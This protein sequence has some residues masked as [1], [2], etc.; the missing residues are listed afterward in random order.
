MNTSHIGRK[1][2][3]SCSERSCQAGL[4]RVRE[5]SGLCL[6]E[7]THPPG[8]R[9]PLHWHE[10]AHFCLLLQGLYE[11]KCGKDV[12]VRK[13]GTLALMA[14]GAIHSNRIYN[15]GIR[16]F[17]IE[18]DRPWLDRANGHLSSLQGL[19]HF[20]KGSL[21]WLATR[22]YHE[23]RCE[24]DVA[25]M[26]IEGL[27]LELLAGLARQGVESESGAATWLKKA[28]DFVHDRFQHSI[29]LAEVAESAGVHP[30]SLARAFRRTHHCTVGDYVRRL[31]VEFACQ[32]LTGSDTP[33][34]DIALSAGF[35]EQSH[36]S[37]TF[38]RLT[39]LT[40]SAYRSSRQG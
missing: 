19:T 5:V 40:P 36:F 3:S 35:S 9:L 20:E 11:E 23:F 10:H 4:I 28:Q 27:V 25:P 30:V 31:R 37:R 39:G 32:K 7:A 18:M 16:F 14:G 22:L 6:T 12:L 2:E 24:D 8:L 17:C 34:V 29:S 38:K 21:P 1:I 33:L 15:T 26:A 13:P